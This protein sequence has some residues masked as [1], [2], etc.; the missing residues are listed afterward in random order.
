MG[1]TPVQQR[2]TDRF[3]PPDDTVTMALSLSL[4]LQHRAELTGL[5]CEH[6]DQHTWLHA[7]PPA[8]HYAT[9]SFLVIM[10]VSCSYKKCRFV[11]ND[12]QSGV[13]Q[14]TLGRFECKVPV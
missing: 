7:V 6:T 13:S 9:Y 2:S 1:H 12:T 5:Q 8:G 11:V 14:V 10:C 4:A 3:L